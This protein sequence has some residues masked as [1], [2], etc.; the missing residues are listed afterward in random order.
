[1]PSDFKHFQTGTEAPTPRSDF[2]IMLT[3]F[4]VGCSNF[5]FDFTSVPP[6]TKTTPVSE[7]AFVIDDLF[8]AAP[9][10][11]DATPAQPTAFPDIGDLLADPTPSTK[12]VSFRGV[13]N[14]HGMCTVRPAQEDTMTDFFAQFAA[15]PTSASQ[16]TPSIPP[17]PVAPISVGNETSWFAFE[18]E[19]AKPKPIA[20]PSTTVQP[21]SPP[22]R[23]PIL[24]LAER[25]E[26]AYEGSKCT[27][28]IAV[29][30]VGLRKHIWKQAPGK[31]VKFRLRSSEQPSESSR[32]RC[33]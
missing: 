7:P 21:A 27:K 22:K 23:G 17:A 2:T 33:N 24:Y 12:H 29:G 18:T 13:F 30:E 16:P 20:V 31:E 5:D 14:E 32:C 10:Q 6:M 25:W 19:E 28:S 11:P 3:R 15:S 1:M 9:K 26:G 8:A 4:T